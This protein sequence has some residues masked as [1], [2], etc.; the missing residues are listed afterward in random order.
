MV[1][2]FGLKIPSRGYSHTEWRNFQFEPNNHY[3]FFF[4][5]T[6]L[7][8]IAFTFEYMLL[9]QFYAKITTFFSIGKCLVRFLSYTLTSKRLAKTD[10]KMTTKHQ[11]WRQNVILTSYKRV[12]LHPSFKTT[13]P[14]PVRVHG[15]SGRVCKK[16]LFDLLSPL[17]CRIHWTKLISVHPTF[18]RLVLDIKLGS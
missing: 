13:F 1:V 9:H 6:L 10:M 16:S 7:S 17:F 2:R 4:L 3:R 12:V 14:I 15:N 11:K 8:T 5:H 18:W